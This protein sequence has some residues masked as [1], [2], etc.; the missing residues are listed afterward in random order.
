MNPQLLND[1]FN[2]IAKETLE[3]KG[4]DETNLLGLINMAQHHINPRNAFLLLT[5]LSMDG[6]NKMCEAFTYRFAL[7]LRHLNDLEKAIKEIKSIAEKQGNEEV[8]GVLNKTYFAGHPEEDI[9]PE[10]E[11]DKI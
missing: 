3:S 8:L 7:V 6:F 9:I 2:Q 11:R 5:G 1:R 4:K 10:G